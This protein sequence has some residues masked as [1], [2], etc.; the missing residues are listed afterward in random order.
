MR[1]TPG[2]REHAKGLVR[3]AFGILAGLPGVPCVFY[4]DEAGME[5]Y[6]DPFCRRPFPWRRVDES[7]LSSYRSVGCLRRDEAVFRDGRFRILSLTPDAF[8]YL[9]E[10]VNGGD[11]VLVAACRRGTLSLSF[12]ESARDLL[13]STDRRRAHVPENGV[14]YFRLPADLDPGTI[15]IDSTVG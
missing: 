4:G 2:E 5:G 15:R 11:P 10:P 8:V 13:A 12:R 3:L 1:M 9:R 14:A 6:R 7:L